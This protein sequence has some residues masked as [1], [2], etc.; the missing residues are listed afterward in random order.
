MNNIETVI[1]QAEQSCQ[2]HGA[3][4]T[5]KRKQIL[6][7]LT[8]SGKALSA[9]ELIDQCKADFGETIS[10]MTMYRVL[11]FLQ[12]EKLVHKLDLS[13]KYIT[14][15]HVVCD[16]QHE[17]VPVFLICNQCNSVKETSIMRSMMDSLRQIANAS[18]YELVSSQLELFCLCEECASAE[19]QVI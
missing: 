7:S 8:Q 9:Y 18:H 6:S 19:Q 15:S 16:H 2:N 10:A 1:E 3:R 11:D 13:N 17:E 5:K 14:C 4:L 12:T